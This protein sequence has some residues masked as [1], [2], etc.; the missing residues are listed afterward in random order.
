MRRPLPE[1]DVISVI[2]RMIRDAGS[3]DL[4]I[5]LA[6][7]LFFPGEWNL[8]FEEIAGV[9]EDH[10]AWA[11]GWTREMRDL[12]SHFARPIGRGSPAAGA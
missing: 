2:E 6:E 7:A 1:S 10:P 8:A 9:A 11:A 3:A 5:G 12:R 4:P